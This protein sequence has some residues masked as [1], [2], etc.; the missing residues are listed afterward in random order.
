M[1]KG[2]V[3]GDPAARLLTLCLG[4]ENLDGVAGRLFREVGAA[5]VAAVAVPLEGRL[6]LGNER[7]R[8]WREG[9]ARPGRCGSGLGSPATRVTSGSSERARGL[10]PSCRAGRASARVAQ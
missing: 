10:P 4:P 1:G 9:R 6:R 5:W 3:R 7:L 2:G 8:A